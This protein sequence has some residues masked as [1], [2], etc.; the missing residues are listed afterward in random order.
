MKKVFFVLSMLLVTAFVHAQITWNVK[1]GVGVSTMRMSDSESDTKSKA[2][3]RLGLG[4]ETPITN[5][6]LFMPS[7]EIATKGTKIVDSEVDWTFDRDVSVTY[8][9]IPLLLAYRIPVESQNLTLKVG[10]YFAYGVSCSGTYKEIYGG[11]IFDG[12]VSTFSDMG[13]ERFDA[14]VTVG[15]GYEYRRF[16]LGVEYEYGLANVI[17][18]DEDNLKVNN[19]AFYV[20]LG[21]K[22]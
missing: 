15:I 8:I 7:L 14:G 11:Q 17:D 22:F 10:P 3:W 5:N 2:V 9:Q 12:T 21:Y 13:A 6:L 1:G 18:I 16:E 20:T 4:I 19:G